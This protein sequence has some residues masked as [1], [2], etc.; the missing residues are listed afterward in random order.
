M[1]KASLAAIPSSRW[2]PEHPK[3]RCDPGTA[4][5]RCPVDAK[6]YI[7]KLLLVILMTVSQGLPIGM[8]GLDTCSSAGHDEMPAQQPAVDISDSVELL[9]Q[10]DLLYVAVDVIELTIDST[11]T[12]QKLASPCMLAM[13]P[14]S[15]SQFGRPPPDLI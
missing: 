4:L 11:L 2:F 8:S 9:D 5:D 6:V 15:E 7:M 1:L 10:F 12:F 3:L 13:S 14:D